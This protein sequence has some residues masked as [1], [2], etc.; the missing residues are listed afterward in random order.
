MTSTTH[1]NIRTASAADARAIY[2]LAALDS[3]RSPAIGRSLVAEEDGELVAAI[4]FGS[5]LA[6]ADPFR[7]TRETVELLRIRARQVA[8]PA[9]AGVQ[10]ALHGRPAVAQ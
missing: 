2:R 4:D 9:R 3:S 10:L 8:E 1:I 5:E 7:R 6:V